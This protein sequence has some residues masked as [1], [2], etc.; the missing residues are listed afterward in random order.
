MPKKLQFIQLEITP[1]NTM[2]EPLPCRC[3]PGDKL[4]F[5][6]TNDDAT[7]HWVS[8]D[9]ADIKLKE[10]LTPANPLDL[11]SHLVKV[12]PQETDIIKAHKVQ[13]AA[14]FGK[15]KL[16]KYT[17][18]KYNVVWADNQGLTINKKNLDPDIDVTP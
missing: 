1:N 2:P 5:V 14:N 16:L 3:H 6:I 13:P 11:G 15:T 8:I 9:A 4:H 7:A 17:T 10:D 18:Y 12:N